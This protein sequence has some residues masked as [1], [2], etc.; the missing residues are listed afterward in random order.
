VKFAVGSI[1]CPWLIL[2]SVGKCPTFTFAAIVFEFVLIAKTLLSLGIVTYA[3]VP[4]GV[5]K[6]PSG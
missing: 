4:S 3:F 6:T 2:T 1:C 5:A